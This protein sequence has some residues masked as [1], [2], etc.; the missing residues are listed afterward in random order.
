[1]TKNNSRQFGTGDVII[2]QGDDGRNAYIIEEGRVEILL[3]QADGSMQ[4]VATRGKGTIIGEMAIVDNQKRIATVRALE[5][6]TLLEI[7]RED[8]TRRLESADAVLQMI[9]KVI[10]MRYRDTL[11]RVGV[12]GESPTYPPPEE[13]E[14][15]AMGN[16]MAVDKIKMANEFKEALTNKELALHYQPIFEMDGKSIVGFEALMRWPRANGEMTSPGQFIPVAEESGLIIEASDWALKEACEALKRIEYAAKVAGKNP[17]P[18]FFMSVNFSALDFAEENFV[19]KLYEIL[20]ETDVQPNQIRLEITESLLM[21]NPDQTRQTLELCKKAGLKISIDDFGTGYSS[22]SYLHSFPIDTIK[23][24]RSF[25]CRM[26]DEANSKALV[27]SLI[28]L[29]GSLNMGTVAEGIENMAEN[30]L[31]TAM[32]CQMV[33][34]FLFARPMDEATLVDWLKTKA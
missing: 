12:L 21:Q 13:M 9:V 20:S 2:K 17:H 29:A 3:E 19:N 31:L 5:T 7:T 26:V 34:G 27:N 30:D 4:L 28:A 11:A 14:R 24:D 6:C 32:G 8:F 1:M 18:P 33:Q 22:L 23:I 16:E 10:L 15:E 25:V